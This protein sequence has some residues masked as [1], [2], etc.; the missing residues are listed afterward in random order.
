VKESIR[1]EGEEVRVL[2]LMLFHVSYIAALF[3][4]PSLQNKQAPS[5]FKSEEIRASNTIEFIL[6]MYFILQNNIQNHHP[7][8]S[9]LY[10]FG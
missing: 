7:G 8:V 10:P 2:F 4:K 6:P 3:R 9:N 5:F 1:R